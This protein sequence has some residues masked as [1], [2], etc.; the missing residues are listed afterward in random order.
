MPTI[1]DQIRLTGNTAVIYCALRDAANGGKVTIGYRELAR[2]AD[3]SPTS[4]GS[5]KSLK[6]LRSLGLIEWDHSGQENVSK[7]YTILDVPVSIA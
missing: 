5:R 6:E 1:V 4:G 3:R 2:R 7:T